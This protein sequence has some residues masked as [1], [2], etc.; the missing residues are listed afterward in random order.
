MKAFRFKFFCPWPTSDGVPLAQWIRHCST[1][2]AVP[3]SNPALVG[4]SGAEV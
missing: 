1:D 2:L 4:E 3:G